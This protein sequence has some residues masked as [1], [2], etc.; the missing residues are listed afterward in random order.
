M[1]L[2][3][4]E[5]VTFNSIAEEWLQYKK[6]TVKESSYL[7]YKFVIQKNFYKEMGG[8]SLEELLQYNFNSFVV[9]LMEELSNKT[10]K[11]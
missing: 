6:A 8:L 2:K 11:G 5:K 7:N 4:M 3:P 10:V 1:D 9:D